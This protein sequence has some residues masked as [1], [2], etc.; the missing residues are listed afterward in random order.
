MVWCMSVKVYR[1]PWKSGAVWKGYDLIVV[2]Q[3]SFIKFKIL[4]L[5]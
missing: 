5:T 1:R 3:T 2:G 4:K